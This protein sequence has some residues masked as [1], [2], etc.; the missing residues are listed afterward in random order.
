MTDVD[1]FIRKA[2]I[3]AGQLFCLFSDTALT[4]QMSK[5]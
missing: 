3:E 5:D 2:A 4:F 1:M